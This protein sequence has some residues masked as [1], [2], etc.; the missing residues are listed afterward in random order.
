MQGE[1]GRP[2]FIIRDC[3]TPL[4]I[5]GRPHRKI[6]EDIKELNN[7][8]TERY[9]Q[10]GSLEKSGGGGTPICVKKA[11]EREAGRQKA[12]QGNR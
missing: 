9:S 12:E 11:L 6:R 8:R 1:I 4:S 5:I 3:N 10:G 7:D 2:Q